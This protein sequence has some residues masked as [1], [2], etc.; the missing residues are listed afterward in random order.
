MFINV[1]L[2]SIIVVHCDCVVLELR[3]M[4]MCRANHYHVQHLDNTGMYRVRQHGYV[5]IDLYRSRQTK[6][7]EGPT[8]VDIIRVGK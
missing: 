1:R 8:T 4:I 2:P 5:Q 6:I 3:M 7:P